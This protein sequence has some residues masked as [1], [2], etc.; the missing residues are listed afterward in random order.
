M[1]IT[2]YFHSYVLNIGCLFKWFICIIILFLQSLSAQVKVTT[3]DVAVVIIATLGGAYWVVRKV[4]LSYNQPAHA[5]IVAVQI[6]VTE[7]L[8]ET[9][10]LIASKF[11]SSAIW[12]DGN[13]EKKKG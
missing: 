7:T 2:L 4:E 13:K 1:S 11:V 3:G 12:L 10:V 5:F 9:C 8:E 6:W